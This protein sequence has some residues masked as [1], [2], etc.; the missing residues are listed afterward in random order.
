[1][2]D[3][4]FKKIE[5]N[6]REIGHGDMTVN[7]NMK[8]LVKSFYNIL[9][10]CEKYRNS[11]LKDKNLFLLKYFKQ[12]NKRKISNNTEL[13]DY[14]NKYEAFC[15]DLSADSVLSGDLRFNYI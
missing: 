10:N 5:I 14:F 2:F 15:F 13:I 12:N 7:K 4:I 11:N 1:M 3:Y 6:M 9:L 8:F